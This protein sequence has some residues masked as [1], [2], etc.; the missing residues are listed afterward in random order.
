MFRPR[1]ALAAFTLLLIGCGYV[2]DPL[3]P[4]A[5][6]PTRVDDL[7]AIQRG[8]RII[9]HFKVPQRTTED[10]AIKAPLKMDLRIGAA[11]QFEENE[12]ANRATQVPAGPVTEGVATYEIPTA[13]WT[14]REVILGVRV[15]AA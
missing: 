9:V 12:W 2:G 11:G 3:P 4:L 10:V 8:S 15:T 5:N 6:I 1:L 14:N 13:E 7:A